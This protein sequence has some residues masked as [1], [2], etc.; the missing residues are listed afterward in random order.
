MG[1]SA[2]RKR[3]SRKTTYTIEGQYPSRIVSNGYTFRSTFNGRPGKMEASRA[4]SEDSPRV[5]GLKEEGC[6][7]G[8]WS[9][10]QTGFAMTE[11]ETKKK[12][13]KVIRSSFTRTAN[14]LEPLLLTTVCEDTTRV[15]WE[16]LSGKHYELKV[17]DRKL[18]EL[19]LENATED[20]L[21]SEL[22]G[23]EL[24]FIR[25][26]ALRSRWEKLDGASRIPQDREPYARSASTAGSLESSEHTD[27]LAFWAQFKKVHEDPFID[28]NDEIEVLIQA[29]VSGS[30]ARQ[31]VESYP[32]MGKNCNTIIQSL[33]DRFGRED[34]QI[35]TLCVILKGDNCEKRVRALIDSGSQRSY[36]KREVAIHLGY[37]P[38]RQ[39]KPTIC[40]DIIPMLSGPWLKEIKDYRIEVSDSSQYGPIELLSGADV[41]G[42]GLGNY[43]ESAC[44][45]VLG[46]QD[47]IEKQNREETEMAAKD[48]FRQTIITDQE[49]RYEVRLSQART[50]SEYL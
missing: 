5:E 42:V 19:L 50:Y 9:A 4:V 3:V 27:W 44:Q 16:L 40:A 1:R 37:T 11:I 6:R 34:L 47:P 43:I 30:R 45:D 7:G 13:R 36:I 32:A 26:T 48:F 20:E 10:P 49:G 23:R 41:A 38:K 24:Y 15:V 39:E 17:L 21:E 25:F 14:E 46:I 29:T 8:V 28:P 2:N 12:C 18:F 22:E 31:L 35:E 33:Q